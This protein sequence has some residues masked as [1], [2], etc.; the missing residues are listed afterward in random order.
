M[1][2]A[3]VVDWAT[4][5]FEADG[6]PLGAWVVTAGAGAAVLGAWVSVELGALVVV[7]GVLVP[8]LWDKATAAASILSLRK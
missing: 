3:A 1:T 4:V 2:V 5:V 7:A 8:F 6:A